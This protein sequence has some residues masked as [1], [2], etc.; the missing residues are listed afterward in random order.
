MESDKQSFLF[1]YRQNYFEKRDEFLRVHLV[2]LQKR[3]INAHGVIQPTEESSTIF[4]FDLSKDKYFITWVD[5]YC[6]QT[7]VL[8]NDKV[9]IDDIDDIKFYQHWHDQRFP[10]QIGILFPPKEVTKTM[11]NEE[12]PALGE[13][14]RTM[15]DKLLNAEIRHLNKAAD[16]IARCYKLWCW[17]KAVLWNP[18]MPEGQANLMIKARLYGL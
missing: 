10:D 13:H 8:D 9:L 11:I 7:F 2:N 5:F 12:I 3:R 4:T 6:K 15:K 16:T 1:V 17:R 14:M 18:H